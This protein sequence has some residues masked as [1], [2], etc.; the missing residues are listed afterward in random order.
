MGQLDG[1]VAIVTGIFAKSPGHGWQEG[2][3][4]RAEIARRVKQG[5]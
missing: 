5:G 4:F 3:E 1:K 2:V